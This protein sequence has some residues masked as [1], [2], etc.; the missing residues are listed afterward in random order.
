MKPFIMCTQPNVPNSCNMTSM[1][2]KERAFATKLN[3]NFGLEFITCTE[4]GNAC[5]DE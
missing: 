5:D 4:T 3:L 1:V 2:T